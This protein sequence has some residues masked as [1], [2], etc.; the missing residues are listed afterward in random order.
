LFKR[1]MLL[2][3]VALVMAAMVVA[4][5]LPALA[6]EESCEEVAAEL[7]DALYYVDPDEVLALIVENPQCFSA[8]NLLAIAHYLLELGVPVEDIDAG[9][10]TLEDEGLI[11]P[12]LAEELRQIIVDEEAGE[13]TEE[14]AEG[15]GLDFDAQE[16]KSGDL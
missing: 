11:S 2:V 12:T 15:V 3:T 9:I 1:I 7:E 13:G 5:A 10:Q 16:L 8:D 14:G 6:Q 4:S